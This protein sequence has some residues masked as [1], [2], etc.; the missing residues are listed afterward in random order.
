[1]R[2][3]T[4]NLLHHKIRTGPGKVALL[5]TLFAAVLGLT[6]LSPARVLGQGEAPTQTGSPNDSYVTVTGEDGA[7][8]RSGPSTVLYPVIVSLENVPPG[9]VLK[10]V[11][12][13][14]AYEWV[15]VVL[16]TDPN[17]VGWIHSSLLS[18]PTNPL[19]VVEPPPTATPL[20]T[21][22]IDPTLAAAFVIEPTATRMPTFTPAP[23]L[24]APTFEPAPVSTGG[25]P[26]ATVIIGLAGMGVL[27]FLLSLLGRR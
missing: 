1:M 10:A 9:T 17:Q 20:V 14:P 3:L 11:G 15:Q 19:P 6:L 16:P 24:V 25:F 23:P 2:F 21:A 8:I 4:K 27:A 22:T 7:N 13:S 26:M 5:S 18:N 12:V